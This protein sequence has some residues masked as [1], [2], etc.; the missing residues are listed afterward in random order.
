[1]TVLYAP[2]HAVLAR[3]AA[4]QAR[5]PVPLPGL[6]PAAAAD[7][8][9]I[10]LAPNPAAFSAAT[11]GQVP[12][13][14]GGVAIPH[15]RRIVIPAYPLPGVDRRQADAILRHE[16]VHLALHERLPR[17]PRWFDEGYA[18]VASG[19]WDASEAWALRLA[20]LTGRA[21]PLDSLALDWPTDAADARL[22]YLLSATAVDHLRRRTGERGFALLLR[23]W[24]ASGSLESSIRTTFGM[25]SAQLED[26][27]AA[28]V[29][30]RYGWL[31]L[32][33]SMGF[34]WALALVLALVAWIPRRMRNRAR[35]AEMEKEYRMLPPPRADW[36]TVDY[37]IAFAHDEK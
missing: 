26:E 25:T 20:F 28:D 13:W 15:L 36:D 6:G 22:A 8:T 14:A 30:S 1:V 18:E 17:I 7:S 23:N 10:V 24:Q 3:E 35:V 5:T 9:V 27:W 33:A 21:P 12:E 19:S 29:R 31:S 37:P 4:A 11:G 34:V 32:A 2:R 16:L